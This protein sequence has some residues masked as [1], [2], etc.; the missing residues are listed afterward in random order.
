MNLT[1][2][3]R[4]VVELTESDIRSLKEETVALLGADEFFP[5]GSTGFS[6]RYPYHERILR[7][8]RDTRP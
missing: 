3:T 7:E 1:K 8:I 2:E 5:V 4:Y 6:Q